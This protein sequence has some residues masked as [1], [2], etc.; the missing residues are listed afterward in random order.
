M[1]KNILKKSLVFAFGAI[2]LASCGDS[3]N[4][5]ID[6]NPPA[7]HVPTILQ[8][9]WFEMLSGYYHGKEFPTPTMTTPVTSV[10]LSTPIVVDG[11]AYQRV[12]EKLYNDAVDELLSTSIDKDLIID[13]NY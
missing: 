8:Q 4:P 5:S 1:K 2:M 9:S 3:D 6:Y 11:V 12:L 10:N 13:N 7:S